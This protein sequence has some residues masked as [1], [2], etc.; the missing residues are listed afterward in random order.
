MS[1]KSLSSHDNEI[2]LGLGPQHLIYYISISQ[3]FPLKNSN[4]RGEQHAFLRVW[5]CKPK[6]ST[7][8]SKVFYYY[9]LW[10]FPFYSEYALEF[11][12][13][14]IKYCEIFSVKMFIFCPESSKGNWRW[15]MFI[16]WLCVAPETWHHSKCLIW[17]SLHDLWT[18]AA[19]TILV[20]CDS[21]NF[22]TKL[23]A[24]KDCSLI[25]SL[26]L[27]ADNFLSD[28][29]L[30]SNGMMHHYVMGPVLFILFY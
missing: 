17:D 24:Y 21:D 7:A 18:A 25:I 11:L 15:T 26:L 23:T 8:N 20:R 6:K 16:L 3:A 9:N 10:N 13:F 1:G 4:I 5:L 19:L 12:C 22:G 28:P 14:D 2:P 30:I 27:A 29:I